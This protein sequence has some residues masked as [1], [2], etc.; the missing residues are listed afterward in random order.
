MKREVKKALSRIRKMQ[1]AVA[2]GKVANVTCMSVDTN[3]RQEWCDEKRHQWWTIY[4]HRDD[5][6]DKCRSYRVAPD[7]LESIPETLKKIAEYIGHEV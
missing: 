7:D 2:D 1:D 4:I 6:S 3:S 5:A